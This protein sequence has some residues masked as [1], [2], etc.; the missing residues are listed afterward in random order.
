MAATTTK[1]TAPKPVSNAGVKKA[2]RPPGGKKNKAKTAM[3]QMQAYCK[4]Q[5]L[6]RVLRVARRVSFL[7]PEQQR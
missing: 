5:R 7:L 4:S 1:T 6:E 2:G 3:I